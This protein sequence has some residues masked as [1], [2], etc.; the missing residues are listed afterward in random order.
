MKK[1]TIIFCLFVISS[2]GITSPENRGNAYNFTL[3]TVQE[4]TS[5]SKWGGV[6]VDFPKVS[7]DLNTQRIAL[8]RD[9]GKRDYF[10]GARW[11]D[12]LPAIVQSSIVDSLQ[13]SGRFAAVSADFANFTS[14][15]KI[16]TNIQHFEAD[17]TISTPPTIRIK[18]NVKLVNSNSSN[19]IKTF[20]AENTAKATANDLESIY[21][22]FDNSFKAVQNDIVKKLTRR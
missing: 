19:I 3:S 13:N 18:M 20:T 8:L 1:F 7:A 17:Y 2:C 21:K 15:Y 11:A 16:E 9:T 5:G 4:K 14:N 6:V 12:F 22:T 10:A